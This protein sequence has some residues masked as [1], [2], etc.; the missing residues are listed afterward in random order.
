MLSENAAG[1]AYCEIV[2]AELNNHRLKPV[3]V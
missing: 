3:V 1:A 2:G